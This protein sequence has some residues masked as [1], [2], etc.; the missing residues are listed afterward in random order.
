MQFTEAKQSFLAGYFATR[1]R[2]AKTQAAYEIDLVQL[3]EFIGTDKPLVDIEPENLESW[4]QHMQT[5]GYAAVSIRRKFATA[6]VFFTYWVRKK[7]I[8]KSP[9]WEIRLDL[10][11]QRLLPR[12]LSAADTKRLI[13]ETWRDIETPDDLITRPN[14]TRFLRLRNAAAIEVLFATGMRVGESVSLKVQ[15]WSEDDSS[16]VVNGK[17]SRQRLAFLPDSRSLK[18][19]RSYLAHRSALNCDHDALFVNALGKQ[20]TTQGIARM[21]ASTAQKAEITTRVTPHRIRHTVATLLLEYGTDIRVVQEV[22]GHASIAT[23]QR[24]THV[25][26]AHMRSTLKDRHPSH[27]LNIVVGGVGERKSV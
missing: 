14:D 25:S 15:D 5:E 17:G 3:A 21:L 8:P 18:A 27:H 22:L 19:L 13:E 12:S 23:T 4:A 6:R 24:Y 9:L 11:R 2:S 10:G 16:F 26:K 7:V 20:I 1:R